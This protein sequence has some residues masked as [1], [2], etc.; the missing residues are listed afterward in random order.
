MSKSKTA[1]PEASTIEGTAVETGRALVPLDAPSDVYRA[2]ERADEDAIVAEVRGDVIETM[3]YE[4]EVSGKQVRGLSYK[5]VNAVVRMMNARGIGRAKISDSTP[6][7]FKRV[8]NDQGRE[9]WECMAYAIDELVGGGRWGIA[10]Q[11]LYEKRRD[12]SEVLDPFAKTKALS[13]SQRNALET[14]IPEDLRVQVLAA[15]EMGQVRKITTPRQAAEQGAANQLQADNRQTTAEPPKRMGAPANAAQRRLLH[16]RFKERGG[17]QAARD[18]G[19]EPE[20]LLK[21]VFGFVGGTA[22]EDKLPKAKVDDVL[23][24]LDDIPGIVV[25]IQ[26]EAGQGSKSAQWIVDNLLTVKEADGAR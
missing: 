9:A 14:L 17:E 12:G 4:F 6:P 23:N 19:I 16:A 2:I 26:A 25:G 1:S 10:T 7:V 24:A 18:L 22:H 11:P 20:Q 13:K 15:F 5:G 21:A 3:A 8:V